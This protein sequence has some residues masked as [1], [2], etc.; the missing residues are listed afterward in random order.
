[1]A[2]SYVTNIIINGNTDFSHTF[3]LETTSNTPLNLTNYTAYAS[4][5]KSSASLN[6]AADFT[7]SFTD[8]LYGKLTIS[9][10]SSITSTIKPGRYSY[11]LLLVDGELTKSRAREGSAIV[12]AGITT[13]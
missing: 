9:L 2:A 3:N 12:T 6:T 8:R 11:D 5:K 4:M 1:M 13:S 10:G 7:V